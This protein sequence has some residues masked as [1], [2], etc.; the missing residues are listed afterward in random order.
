MGEPERRGTSQSCAG[1]R[2]Q[3]DHPGGEGRSGRRGIVGGDAGKPLL[4]EMV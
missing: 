2:D 4:P 3:A 1:K